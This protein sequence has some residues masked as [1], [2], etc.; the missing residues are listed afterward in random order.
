MSQFLLTPPSSLTVLVNTNVSLPCVSNNSNGVSWNRTTSAN[1]MTDD[2]AL[3]IININPDNAGVYTCTSGRENSTVNIT[4]LCKLLYIIYY[5]LLLLLLTDPPQF[6]TVPDNETIVSIN[7]NVKMTC[8]ARGNPT[9]SIYWYING[10]N[11]TMMMSSESVTDGLTTTSNITLNN[12]QPNSTGIYQCVAVGGVVSGVG[13]A[14]FNGITSS[15]YLLVRCKLKQLKLL[16]L[17]FI[18]DIQDIFIDQSF[19]DPVN[20]L[21]PEI[22]TLTCTV[23]SQ[24]LT[25]ITWDV[26]NVPV[27]IRQSPVGFRG[28]SLSSLSVNSSLLSGSVSFSCRGNDTVN[29]TTVINAFSKSTQDMSSLTLPLSL[30]PSLTL[31]PLPPS[32]PSLSLLSLTL[33]H[34]PSSPSLLSLTLSLSP[35]HLFTAG[36]VTIEQNPVSPPVLILRNNVS[37]SCS[38]SSIPIPVINWFRNASNGSVSITDDITATNISDTAVNSTLTINITSEDQFGDYFCVASNGFFNATSTVAVVIRGGKLIIII[39]IIIIIDVIICY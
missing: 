31:P 34:S 35:S 22:L 27:T 2:M 36:P 11:R 3:S 9:P 39:I 17:L 7:D 38:A 12:V 10:T 5:I 14:S 24:P 23:N 16:K 18:T 6:L 1:I 21:M 8:V 4:V 37:F 13:V 28:P 30:P 19:T 20:P 25:N 33:P 15:T 29:E 32:S 26:G